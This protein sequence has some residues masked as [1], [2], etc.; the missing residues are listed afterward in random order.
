[1]SKFVK[2]QQVLIDGKQQAT[3]LIAQ[4]RVEKNGMASGKDRCKVIYN[5]GK[6]Q[7]EVWIPNKRLSAITIQIV[8]QTDDQKEKELQ[9]VADTPREAME[10][11]EQP[12]IDPNVGSN[13]I[14]GVNT[15]G[16]HDHASF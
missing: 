14:K 9:A 7:M 16:A 4:T 15:A 8:K 5:T 10:W 3:I 12:V 1:M 13:I 6:S 11:V 2:G